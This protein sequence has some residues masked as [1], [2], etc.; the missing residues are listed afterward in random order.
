M[1]QSMDT[2]LERVQKSDLG[3]KILEQEYFTEREVGDFPGTGPG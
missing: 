2:T 1:K 3:P